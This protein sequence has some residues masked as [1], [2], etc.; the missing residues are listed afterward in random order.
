MW[1]A[2]ATGPGADP[3]VADSGLALATVTSAIKQFSP[4]S[5]RLEIKFIGAKNNL[6]GGA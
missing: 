3:T 6:C 5:S 4:A 1:N 2:S